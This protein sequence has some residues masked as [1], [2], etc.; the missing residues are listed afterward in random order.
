MDFNS[1]WPR[2]FASPLGTWELCCKIHNYVT[3][4]GNQVPNFQT[5]KFHKLSANFPILVH[6]F[7]AAMGQTVCSL[8]R[9]LQDLSENFDNFSSERIF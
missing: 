3:K 6:N 1:L 4:Y 9:L 5:N 8:D 7:E 2:R